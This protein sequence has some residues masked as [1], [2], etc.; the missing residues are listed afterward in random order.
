MNVLGKLIFKVYAYFSYA[1]ISFFDGPVSFL[2]FPLEAHT[3]SVVDTS[4]QF[5]INL[6]AFEHAGKGLKSN[7]QWHTHIHREIQVHTMEQK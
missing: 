4:I 3:W 6:R 5:G 7:Y 1:F 2:N